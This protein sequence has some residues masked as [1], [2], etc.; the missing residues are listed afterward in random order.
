MTF[1]EAVDDDDD[2]AFNF[3]K[4]AASSGTKQEGRGEGRKAL[5]GLSGV[6]LSRGERGEIK[7]EA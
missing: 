5:R 7:R 4:A 2:I 3:E 1:P 6:Y